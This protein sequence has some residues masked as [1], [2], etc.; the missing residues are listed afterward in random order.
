MHS[1]ELISADHRGHAL[2]WRSGDTCLLCFINI[3]QGA[4]NQLKLNTKLTYFA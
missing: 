1:N 4:T 3:L 2:E